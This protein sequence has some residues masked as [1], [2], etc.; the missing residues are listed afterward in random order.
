MFKRFIPLYYFLLFASY[1]VVM[2]SCSSPTETSKG[3]FLGMV[4]LEGETDYSGITIALYDLAYLDTTIIRINNQYPQI[5]V[6]INQHTEFDHRFQSPA[7][8]TETLVDGSFE[9]TEIPTGKYNFVA[10]KDG[11]GFKYLYE[12]E[13]T[14]GDNELSQQIVLFT[15]QHISGIMQVDITVETDHHL[16]IDN[17]TDFV[18]GTNLT[19]HSGAVIRINPGVD[20]TILGTMS[21]QGE[22]NT[23]F[24]ITSN[25]G[26][27]QDFIP[28]A[29]NRN[30]IEFYN[31]IELSPLASVSDD[32]IEWGKL[33]T[34]NKLLE[35]MVPDLTIQH[36]RCKNNNGA[37]LVSDTF[38]IIIRNI[39]CSFSENDSNGGIVAFNINKINL[40]NSILTRNYNG[41][42]F[43]DC[44]NVSIVN[45]SFSNNHKGILGLTINGLIQNNKFSSQIEFD[46][47]LTSY[48][49]GEH[50]VIELNEICSNN[51]IRL[52]T[53]GSHHSVNDLEVNRNNMRCSD[54]F[55]EWNGSALSLSHVIMLNENYFRGLVSLEEILLYIIDKNVI[56]DIF[57]TLVINGVSEF[58]WS[59]AGIQ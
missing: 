31:S 38:D 59:E 7:K 37:I 36:L 42:Y 35:S 51:G 45:S 12:V 47:E 23:M 28:N 2:A 44:D 56:P 50:L 10:M 17:D 49:T 18:P 39:N 13:I 8:Y 58:P 9:L 1:F 15:E 43:K 3:S 34:G 6:H 20:L 5:G 25:D 57:V 48:L 24:W 54:L 52:F 41:I 19:I 4:I 26:F 27:S 53:Q 14:K 29:L 33:D 30:E 22:E 16:V 40:S 55:L 11:W 46:I 21:A 32:L